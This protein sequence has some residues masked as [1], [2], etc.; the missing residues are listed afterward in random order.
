MRKL[1]NKIFSRITKYLSNIYIP[2]NRLYCSI[3]GVTVGKGFKVKG[4]LFIRNN[5]FIQIGDKVRINSAGWANPIGC[6]D[7]TY[8]QVFIGGKLTIGN[9][10]A[11]S[12]CAFTVANE[13]MI[14]DN[15]MIGAGCKLYDTDFHPINPNERINGWK[16]NI[17]CKPIRIKEGAFIGANAIVL[18]GVTIGENAVIGAGSIV[19]KNVPD[20]EIWAGNPAKR[21]GTI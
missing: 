19:T 16:Q 8:I 1:I 21:I 18:K 5:G 4:L 13:I 7:R 11:I 3:H 12:N 9:G 17:C 6:G 20:N 2:L 14:E 10:C 15:V